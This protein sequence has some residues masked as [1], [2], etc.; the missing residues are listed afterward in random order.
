MKNPLKFRY[1]GRFIIVGKDQNS[2][3][4]IYGA[5]GRSPSSLAR[6]F[7]QN[8]DAIF[9]GGIDDTVKEGNPALLEYPA[10]RIFPNGILVANGGHIDKITELQSR[11]ARKQ[12][13]Y[14]LSEEAYEP[15][16]YRTPRITG[17]IVESASGM[18]GAL[19]IVRSA[20]NGIDKS[21]WSVP[22]E[23]G[24]GLFVGTYEGDDVKPTPSFPGDPLPVSL[25]FGSTHAAAKA[26]FDSYAPPAG[27]LDYRVGII[28][29]YKK[30]GL[31]PEIAIIN[32]VDAS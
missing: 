26:V 4:V 6:K 30:P 20:S 10:V 32:R 13:A 21:S 3:V 8:G 17:C 25:N 2:Y 18:D 23:E 14:A 28:A 19:H 29:V 5:T 9:M 22:F 27:G 7:V 12:L 24:K 11:D 31:A 15:D 16:E 1:P